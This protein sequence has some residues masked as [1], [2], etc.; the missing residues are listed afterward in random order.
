MEK[1]GLS[2]KELQDLRRLYVKHRR[3]F[4]DTAYIKLGAFLSR[5]ADRDFR[6]VFIV[7]WHD[8]QFSKLAIRFLRNQGL[9][10]QRVE[11]YSVYDAA[12]Q[13]LYT[14]T[15]P[16][17]R[18]PRK[19]PIRTLHFDGHGTGDEMSV[20]AGTGS[21]G[22]DD[23]AV[24]QVLR[25]NGRK[26]LSH[27]QLL[28]ML[29]SVLR[30]GKSHVELHGCEIAQQRENSRLPVLMAQCLK[31]PVVAGVKTQHAGF[32]GLGDF[33]AIQTDLMFEGPVAVGYPGK[34]KAVILER[35]YL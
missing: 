32:G 31:V 23:A 20:G 30:P 28:G 35:P 15:S 25:K 3:L 34:S 6:E 19:R 18:K 2:K 7:D 33:N 21:G 8:P 17:D 11:A 5:A 10:V 26:S 22:D 14:S 29:R 13:T 16:L 27:H 1:S 9:L 24:L 12:V 4:T